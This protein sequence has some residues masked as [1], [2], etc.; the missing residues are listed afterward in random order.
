MLALAIALPA[1]APAGGIPLVDPSGAARGTVKVVLSRGLIQLKI[2][3]LARLPASISTGTNTFTAHEYKAYLLSSADPAVEIFLGDIYPD[4][5]QRTMR[6]AVLGGDL[7][8]MGFDRIV[9]TA[10]SKDGQSAFDVLTATL[11]P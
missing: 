6:K 7:T 11:A 2:A 5:R 8:Q 10:F 1:S 9:V 4:A 3:S